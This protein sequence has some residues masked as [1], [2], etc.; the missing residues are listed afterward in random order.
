[1]AR[2][3]ERGVQTARPGRHSDGDGLH[4]VV[5]ETG[6]KKWVLRYQVAGVR[7]DKGLGAYPSVELRD[8][9]DRAIEARKLVARGIDPIEADRAAK[10]TAK[11]IPTFRE[12]AKLVIEDAQSKSV[13]A[14]VRYQWERLLG[15]AYSGPL[16]DRFVYE[17]TALDVA[18]VLRP[19]WR[20]KPE[21]ARKLY[22]AIRRVFDRARVVL[23]DEHGIAMQDNPA[24]WDDLKAMGF[25]TPKEL[26]KGNY[27]SLSYGQMPDFIA[28][29][30]ARKAT[31]ALAL[32][33]LILTNV[34]TN[35]ILEAKWSEFDLDRALWSVPL[36]NLKDRGHRKVSFEVPLSPRAVEIVREVEKGRISANVFPGRSKDQPLSNMA[37]LAL[38]KRM[39]GTSKGEKPN[40]DAKPIWHDPT[41]G[42]AITPHGFRA[43]FKTWAEEV[44]TFPHA[45]VEH[46]MGPK[47]GGKVE[48]AYTRTTLLEMRRKL[49]DLWAR[50]CEPRKGG[51]VI[52]MARMHS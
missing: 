37:F 33:L 52:S 5:S 47:V 16:L 6:R 18:A 43:T 26:T 35:A 39:N 3:S 20:S 30:R 50:H 11:P 41:S 46:A 49:M 19:V 51:N 22:P 28:A 7:R 36:V 1:M 9:R 13:N 23:R 2:L 31:A 8:A 38:L 42:R 4:L 44:A 21:V 10:K 32:E 14:K 40:P 15:P 29:L 17:I 34:R 48:R 25:E 12:I 27:P 24:R 45:A